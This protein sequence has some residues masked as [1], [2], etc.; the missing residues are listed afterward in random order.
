VALIIKSIPDKIKVDLVAN[1]TLGIIP[2]LMVL[3]ERKK[4]F[5]II[6]SVTINIP[7][8]L[9]DLPLLMS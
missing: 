2:I 4:N 5:M 7:I 6:L 9:L 8:N 3:I 1:L